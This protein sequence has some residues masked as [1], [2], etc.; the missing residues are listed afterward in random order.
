ML[1]RRVA[2]VTT[3]GS[4]VQKDSERLQLRYA[5]PLQLRI[6]SSD[7]GSGEEIPIEAEEIATCLAEPL[8][9]LHP[10]LG[11]FLRHPLSGDGE[12][13]HD[14]AIRDAIGVGIILGVEQHQDFAP[15]DVEAGVLEPAGQ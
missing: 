12:V 2:S 15:V 8:Q 3:A 14:L 9:V 11:L 10:R 5:A 6:G 7:S 1:S 4:P 13:G